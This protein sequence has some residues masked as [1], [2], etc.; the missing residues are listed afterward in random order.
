[1]RSRSATIEARGSVPTAEQSRLQLLIKQDEGRSRRAD[2]TRYIWR[3]SDD[4]P[5]ASRI[6]SMGPSSEI[7]VY[8]KKR[9]DH[10]GQHELLCSR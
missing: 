8:A 1:M 9:S 2:L 3:L 5:G 6:I 10:W 7:F 4:C